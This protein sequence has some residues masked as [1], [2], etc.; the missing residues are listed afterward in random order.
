MRALVERGQE[1]G[2]D[3][4][5]AVGD[6]HP[7]GAIRADLPDHRGEAGHAAPPVGAV[8]AVEVVDVDDGEGGR[9]GPDR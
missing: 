5:A 1:R 9:L 4:V 8:E 3:R 7:A 2:G 6:Q